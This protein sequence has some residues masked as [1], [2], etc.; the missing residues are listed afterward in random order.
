[1]FS[2]MTNLQPTSTSLLNILIGLLLC[3]TASNTLNAQELR[4]AALDKGFLF[5]SPLFNLYDQ[6][7]QQLFI[8]QINIGT[9]PAYWK[10]TTHPQEGVYTWADMDAA[11]NFGEQNGWE[12]HGHPLVWGSDTFIPDWVKGKPFGD[13]EFIMLDHIRTVA[14]RYGNRIKTW[15]VVNEAIEDDGTYRDCYW[16]RAMTGEFIA[17]A[18]IEARSV[19][20]NGVLLY[21]DYGIE[22]NAAKFNTVKSML[23]WIQTLGAQVDGLGWQ[24][25][26]DVNT[27]LDPN[28]PLEQ[29]MM[30]ISN[31]GL[32]NYITELD[33]RMPSNTPFERERQKLAFRKIAEIFMC[34]PTAGDYFQC[35]DISD[36]HTWW[37]DFQPQ[38][39]PFYPLPFDE[40]FNKKPAYWGMVDAFKSAI[41]DEVC[42]QPSPPVIDGSGA[43]WGQTAYSL[44]NNILGAPNASD[45]SADFQLTWDDNYL[46]VYGSVT[47][48]ILTNDSGGSAYEDDGFEIYIDGN[49]DRSFTYDGNDHQLMFRVN[50]PNVIYWSNNQT[51]NP[52]GV[53]FARAITPNGYDIEVRIAWSFIG[54]SPFSGK[55]LGIDIHVNDDDDGGVRD[56]KIAWFAREDQAWN[57]TSLFNT[58]PL[59]DNQ[60][61]NT[62]RVVN[63][64][65]SL[66]LEGPYFP[67][68]NLMTTNLLQINLLPAGQPYSGA[69][70][71]YPGTEG[72][73]W[74][75]S[76]YPAGSVDWVLVSLRTSPSAGD[77]IARFAS[78]LLEDG[79]TSPLAAVEVSPGITQVYVVVE[80]RNHLPVMSAMPVDI[81]NNTISYDFRI[82]NSY[83]GPSGTGFG[84]KAL[85][86][87]NWAL[88]AGNA[89]Q[90]NMLGFEITGADR[91]LWQVENGNFGVYD[92]TDFDF[93]G[94]VSGQDRVVWSYNNGVSSAV[95]RQ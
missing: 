80:H 19:L 32:K 50:D 16:N 42:K 58:I 93:N 47:D 84:Q 48:D 28:F 86:N 22:S 18:F 17:K 81:I 36:R 23:G 33:I 95:P 29:F 38:N 27:V 31:M 13:A 57:N 35:W 70:W 8:D 78:L 61:I 82:Q 12:L 60:C 68:A 7:Y 64:A 77:E 49:N 76:D 69:P 41:C 39:A 62:T 72:A 5:G 79:T 83:T 25:H 85:S 74:S 45:L 75:S 66:L 26:T 54:V 9:I 44:E 92:V 4:Q 30:D 53:D 34:N 3:L 43:E 67:T 56:S 55:Y 11:V 46:Y 91:V 90:S 15:D 2:A 89:D 40:N 59:S 87:G 21:N 63:C 1:M 52:A 51:T 6:Q 65:P 37:N 20:P 88:F 14:G 24:M 94:D 71:N 73:G 10:F